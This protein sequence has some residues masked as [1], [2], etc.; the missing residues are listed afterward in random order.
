MDGRLVPWADAK[1]HVLT[2]SLHYGSAVFEGI[3]FYQTDRGPAI[4]RLQEHVDR[5]FFSAETMYMKIPFSK[6][7]ISAA[8]ISTVKENAVQAGYIR[9]LI[10]YGYGKM[11]L[12]VADAP[13]N[14][15]IAVWPWGAYLGEK[16]VRIKTSSLARISSNSFHVAAKV[17]GHYVNSILAGEEAKRAGYDEALLLDGSGKIA[18]GQGENL[19]IC[20][21]GMLL[22]PE[23][24]SILPGITRSSIIDLAKAQGLNITEKPLTL[25]DAYAADEAFYT[26]T[27]AEVTAIASIDD[28]L[29]LQAPGEITQKIKSAF[30]NIV[31]GKDADFQHWLTF[32]D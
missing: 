3:R 14:V 12:G 1:I 23:L 4:F 20:K 29:L 24:G 22:T 17:S 15:S 28:H 18:E 31:S 21:D 10:Y 26:G 9:P 16:P 7:D 30:S 5:L 25:E 11:G 32:I 6:E 8:I 27:A 13:V 19:F 2:H